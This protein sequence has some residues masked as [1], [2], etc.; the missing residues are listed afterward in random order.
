MRTIAARASSTDTSGK[1]QSEEV[2]LP[3]T[4]AIRAPLYID[5][6]ITYINIDVMLGASDTDVY[7]EC[8]SSDLDVKRIEAF[9]QMLVQ[10]REIENIVV[11]FGKI[12]FI[13]WDYLRSC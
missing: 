10:V 2:D 6:E 11:G 13:E 4:I 12:D 1:A 9:E 5:T 8:C 7:V 3:E